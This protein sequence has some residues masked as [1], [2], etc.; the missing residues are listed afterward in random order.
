[1]TFVGHVIGSGRHGPDPEKVKSVARILTPKTKSDLRKIL[2]FFSYFRL[3]LPNFAQ[4]ARPLTDMTGKQKSNILDWTQDH[5]RVLETLKTML[6][7]A[8]K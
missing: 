7:D 4:I 2:G 6:C 1:V 5:Q 8:T 3:Y